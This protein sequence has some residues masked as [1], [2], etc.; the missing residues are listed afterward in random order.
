[1]R[2]MVESADARPITPR[3]LL[4]EAH[5]EL[6]ERLATLLGASFDVTAVS[7]LASALTAA[8]HVR[9][10]V[11]LAG[12]APPGDRALLRAL[13]AEPDTSGVPVILLSTPCDQTAAPG[14][15]GGPDDYVVSPFT[16]QEL[17]TRVQVQLR[18]HRRSGNAAPHAAR[19]EHLHQ[20]MHV[21]GVSIMLFD[22]EGTLLD[23]NGY[24]LRMFG[25]SRE[26][27]SGRTL[28]WRHLTP[29]EHV[30][31]RQHELQRLTQTGRLGPCEKQYLRKDGTLTWML[32][33]SAHLGNGTFIEYCI[34]INERKRV[35]AALRASE[36]RLRLIVDSASDYAIFTMD[37]EGRIESWNP[38]A[39]R[40]F[41]WSEAEAV[42]RHGQMIFT[43]EDQRR[44]VPQTELALARRFGRAADE[45]WHSRKD[46]SRFYASGVLVTLSSG[47]GPSG[48]AKIARDLTPRKQLEDALRLAHDS[49]EEQ[50]A[51]RTAQVKGLFNRVV[52]V[53]EEERRRIAADLHDQLGQQM[54]ALRLHL[55]AAQTVDDAGVAQQQLAESR[56]LAEEIDRSIDFLTWD[57]R[58]PALDQMGLPPMLEG[59]VR[60]WSDRF[61]VAAEFVSHWNTSSRPNVVV[62]ANLYRLTQEALHNVFKHAAA[63]HVRVLLESRDGIALLLVE[64]NGRGFDAQDS[65]QR[66][67]AG[68]LGLVSMR[69]RANLMGADLTIESTPGVG[70]SI[71]VQ[72]PI[73]TRAENGGYGS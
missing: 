9:P 72:V 52:A 17:V 41:G 1:M 45:R 20:M 21:D 5:A 38:G 30:E 60:G 36:E 28:T 64:D 6:R 22:E 26:Q 63:S 40:M 49:L 51:R 67:S 57:L 2:G 66:S 23:A 31:V 4:A 25:Y 58:P 27:V 14:T 61:G 48:F 19:D 44:G 15:A 55:Q 39:E 34:D 54:T 43:P 73:R 18:R 56:R 24:F 12:L 59:L 11:V 42:G 37:A 3:I 69:E 7:D 50:V 10:D 68:G 32:F 47:S 8:R 71:L 16:D 35:E 46:H 33:A 13:R 62:E 70:T 29:D 53:Q 65:M